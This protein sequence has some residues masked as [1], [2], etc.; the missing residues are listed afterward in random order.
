[1]R[2]QPRR[3]WCWSVSTSAPPGAKR[4]TATDAAGIG[5]LQFMA[6]GNWKN[7]KTGGLHVDL[8]A[9]SEKTH[10]AKLRR[11]KLPARVSEALLLTAESAR[12]CRKKDLLQ[13]T[14]PGDL[15]PEHVQ[16]Q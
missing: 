8:T 2:L 7:A 15:I 6:A 12:I 9:K 13:G 16:R 3:D 11:G 4:A 1:M 14:D 5:L 10:A